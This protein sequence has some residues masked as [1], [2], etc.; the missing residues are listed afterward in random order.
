VEVF[1]T[2]E[3]KS[4]SS[5]EEVVGGSGGGGAAAAGVG[6]TMLVI[7]LILNIAKAHNVVKAHGL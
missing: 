5:G 4:F 2:W 1:F 6:R 3:R 7:E